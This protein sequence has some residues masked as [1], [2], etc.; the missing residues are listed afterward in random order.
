MEVFVLFQ[1][2]TGF[3][4]GGNRK[5]HGLFISKIQAYLKLIQC[6][7][8]VVIGYSCLAAMRSDS[9]KGTRNYQRNI[10]NKPV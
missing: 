8:P 7:I 2:C 10:S 9:I 3:L 1:G 4:M 6:V 5:I